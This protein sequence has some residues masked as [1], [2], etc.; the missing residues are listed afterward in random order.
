MYDPSHGTGVTFFENAL[1]II[2]GQK[3]LILAA[4]VWGIRQYML[5]TKRDTFHVIYDSF[6]WTTGAMLLGGL[7]LKLDWHL[8]YYSAMLY[9]LPSIVFFGKKYFK[10]IP[11]LIILVMFAGLHSYKIPQAIQTNQKDRTE[12]KNFVTFIVSQHQKGKKITWYELE[13]DNTTSYDL[14]LRDWKK[15]ALRTYIQYEL[16]DRTWEYAISDAYD[17]CIVLYSNENDNL[18]VRPASLSKLAV[19]TLNGISLYEINQYD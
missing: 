13:T 14:I 3:F 11:L 5:I 6:L 4:L 17:E 12:Q 15:N 7:I 16:K 18:G 1:K 10:K 9:A 2:K 8:Y 19:K